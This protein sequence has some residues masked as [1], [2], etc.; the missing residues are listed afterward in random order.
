MRRV[1]ATASA[2]SALRRCCID[3]RTTLTRHSYLLLFDEPFSALD[4]PRR[5]RLQRSLRELQREI[6]AVTIIVTH[7]PDDA[8]LLADNESAHMPMSSP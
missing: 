4:T 3:S 8:A 2:I 1:L 6:S 7:D 5:R